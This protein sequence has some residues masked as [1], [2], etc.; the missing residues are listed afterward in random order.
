MFKSAAAML[1]FV[2]A[3]GACS[4]PHAA[5]PQCTFEATSP[6]SGVWLCP[7]SMTCG[8]SGP[9]ADGLCHGLTLVCA[10]PCQTSA[11]CAALGET[12]VCTSACGPSVC[13]PYQ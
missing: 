1:L 6:D 12:A 2:G 4:S 5:L 13:T 3:S 9:G 11:D 7:G 10:L 8:Y